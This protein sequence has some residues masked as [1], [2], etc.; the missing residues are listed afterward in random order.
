MPNNS[1]TTGQLAENL[2]V[3]TKRPV[4]CTSKVLLFVMPF[5]V[6]VSGATVAVH[7]DI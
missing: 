4:I 6:I 2:P 3:A 5:F 1:S 7:T